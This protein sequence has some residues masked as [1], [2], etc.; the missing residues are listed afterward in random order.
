MCDNIIYTPETCPQ[1]DTWF[2]DGGRCGW[3]WVCD[4]CTKGQSYIDKE[5]E[6]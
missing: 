3:A 6:R 5:S 2:A 1:S 4:K